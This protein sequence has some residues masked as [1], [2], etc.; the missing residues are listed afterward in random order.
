MVQPALGSASTTE[1][2]LPNGRSLTERADAGTPCLV[3]APTGDGRSAS[4]SVPL[5]FAARRSADGG[6]AAGEV[7]FDAAPVGAAQAAEFARCASAIQPQ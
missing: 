2:R 1:E 5:G 3:P 7:R 4:R 6:E